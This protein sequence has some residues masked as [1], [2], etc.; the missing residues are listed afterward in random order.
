MGTE[1]LS[2]D[3]NVLIV[4]D[5]EPIRSFLRIALSV[6]EGV[7]EVREA[8]GGVQALEQCTD[9]PPDVVFLD[10]WMP[11][12]DGDAAAGMIRALCPEVHIVAFSGVLETKPEWADQLCVKGTLPDLQRMLQDARNKRDR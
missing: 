10:Y 9:F 2:R 8:A 7:G 12:M 3:L 6:E 1:T 11:G 5:D 4:D